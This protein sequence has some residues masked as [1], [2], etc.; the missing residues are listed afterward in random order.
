MLLLTG[1]SG[2]LGA[3][4]VRRLLADGQAVRVLLRAGSNNAAVDNLSVD[5]VYGDLRDPRTLE[6][7][8]D[9]CELVYHCAAKVSTL[10]GGERETREIYESNVLGTHNLLAAARSAKVRRVVVSGSFSAIGHDPRR[11][12][13]ETIPFNPF[14]HPMPYELSKTL[15]ELECLKAVVDGLDVVIATSCAIIGPNDFKPSRMGQLLLDFANGKLRA[16]IGGGFEFVAARDIVEGHL[17]AM[18]RGR[19]GHKYIFGTEFVTVDRLLGIY[20]RITG[21][22]R[23]RLRLPGSVM[24]AVAELSTGAMTRF[25]PTRPQRFTPG[26]V[27]L[28]RM[29]RHADCSKARQELGY[30]PT[31]I[32]GAIREAYD[33][34][35]ERGL[36]EPGATPR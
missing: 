6:I 12:S 36:L 5:R 25:A 20:E 26:A 4:L 18:A 21:R 8:M 22:Q 10:P 16:Y 24:A 23:P 33:S 29:G 15:V 7:A 11:P 30:Q 35:V 17:L 2:H 3:N 28:L 34:F 19:P 32:D 1:A 9:G 14:D 31:S 27:R 13:N